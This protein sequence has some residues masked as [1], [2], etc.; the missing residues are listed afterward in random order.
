[1]SGCATT[2][3]DA[4]A[5]QLLTKYAQNSNTQLYKIEREIKTNGKIPTYNQDFYDSLHSDLAVIDIRM[6]AMQQGQ[7]AGEL[8]F[9]QFNHFNAL[10]DDIERTHKQL[11]KDSQKTLTLNDK[12]YA[13]MYFSSARREF[14]SYLTTLISHEAALKNSQSS[15]DSK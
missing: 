13:I 12:H 11:Y 15:G 7:K 6:S 8:L 3:Y 5:D 1:M 2:Y 10:I 14:N 9:L 4:Q